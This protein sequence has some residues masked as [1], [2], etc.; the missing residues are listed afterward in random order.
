LTVSKLKGII[1]GK[2]LKII[3]NEAPKALRRVCRQTIDETQVVI[4]STKPFA[5]VQASLEQLI[6]WI[7]GTGVCHLC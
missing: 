2:K 1:D 3:I 7:D 4:E 6:P 5:D